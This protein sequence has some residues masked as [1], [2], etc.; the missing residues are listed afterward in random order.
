M[1]L[2]NPRQLFAVNVEDNHRPALYALAGSYGVE[3]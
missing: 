1:K 3:G 2:W